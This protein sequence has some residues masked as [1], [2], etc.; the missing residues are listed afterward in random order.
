VLPPNGVGQQ[1]RPTFK[2]GIDLLDRSNQPIS[3]R[4]PRLPHRR[5]RDSYLGAARNASHAELTRTG[6]LT[7]RASRS[8]DQVPGAVR[9]RRTPAERPDRMRPSSLIPLPGRRYLRVACH[10]PG[11]AASIDNLATITRQVGYSTEL[12]FNGASRVN[13]ARQRAASAM[14]LIACHIPQLVADIEE[15]D[16]VEWT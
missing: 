2:P 14:P 4:E 11:Q 5:R 16:Q 10:I 8:Y 7:S 9:H 3:R 6:E 13:T 15:R 12:A 1:C